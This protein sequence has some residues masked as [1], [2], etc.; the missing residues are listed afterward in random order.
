MEILWA[1]IRPQMAKETHSLGWEPGLCFLRHVFLWEELHT[2]LRSY[3]G[4]NR[5]KRTGLLS[6]WAQIT[7]IEKH[8]FPRTSHVGTLGPLNPWHFSK[9][10]SMSVSSASRYFTK[11]LTLSEAVQQVWK[12]GPLLLM[13]IHEMLSTGSHALHMLSYWL[14]TEI[15][16]CQYSHPHLTEKETKVQK[17]HML[18]SHNERTWTEPTCAW[19]WVPCY[20]F[21]NKRQA[22]RNQSV[23][24]ERV[25]ET[26]WGQ[27]AG[28]HI[29]REKMKNKRE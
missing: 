7:G 15:L 29:E 22:R 1:G 14:L 27:R 4:E 8:H 6:G 16:R 5:E 3:T 13:G 28:D 19:L 21:Q 20:F 24:T 23:S 11:W 9:S 25:K 26:Y 18:Q 12:V 2:T 10:E 17:I